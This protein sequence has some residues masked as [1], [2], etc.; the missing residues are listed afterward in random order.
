MPNIPKNSAVN[1]HKTVCGFRMCF[2]VHSLRARK[3]SARWRLKAKAEIA[4]ISSGNLTP[5]SVARGP[6][7][8]YSGMLVGNRAEEKV[9]KRPYG[10]PTRIKG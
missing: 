7:G 5:R 4:F 6:K 8:K 10:T 1:I 9:R 3:G 2:S